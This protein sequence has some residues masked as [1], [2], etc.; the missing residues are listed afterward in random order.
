M[1]IKTKQLLWRLAPDLI[2]STG[3]VKDVGYARLLTWTFGLSAEEMMKKE[4]T[5]MLLLGNAREDFIS[6]LPARSFFT[7]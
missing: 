7:L 2:L 5:T 3:L 6:L 4:M 1:C